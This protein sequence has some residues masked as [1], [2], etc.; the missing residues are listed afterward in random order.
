MTTPE[1]VARS[2]QIREISSNLQGHLDAADQGT[3]NPEACVKDGFKLVQL[4][5]ANNPAVRETGQDIGDA[6][7]SSIL[8]EVLPLF[9]RYVDEGNNRGI[10]ELASVLRFFGT[11]RHP[12][13][14]G[15]VEVYAAQFPEID[16]VLPTSLP[17]ET[18]TAE[19]AAASQADQMA[20]AIADREA[21][22]AQIE[23]LQ[24]R[25]E[26]AGDDL[27]RIEQG[28]NRV[29]DEGETMAN[30][31]IE[32]ARTQAA[33]HA[34]Q[35]A[36]TANGVNQAPGVGSATT[37]GETTDVSS[38]TESDS[39]PVLALPNQLYTPEELA[40]FT[41][42]QLE[43]LLNASQKK[44][45]VTGNDFFGEL[46]G[47]IGEEY[48]RRTEVGIDTTP[49]NLPPLA[50]TASSGPTV[51][52]SARTGEILTSPPTVVIS[53]ADQAAATTSET[54]TTAGPTLT[55]ELDQV[56]QFAA[57]HPDSE[58]IA[59]NPNLAAENRRLVSRL[60]LV[61]DLSQLDPSIID[62]ISTEAGFTLFSIVGDQGNNAPAAWREA[63]K[64]VQNEL[65]QVNNAFLNRYTEIRL[66]ALADRLQE[67]LPTDSAASTGVPALD[68]ERDRLIGIFGLTAGGVS[69]PVLIKTIKPYPANVREAIW[70][71]FES[72]LPTKE[73]A[74]LRIIDDLK[75]AVAI[76]DEIL[77][78]PK[79]NPERL[80]KLI[81][82]EDRADALQGQLSETLGLTGE[83]S[84]K[85]AYEQEKKANGVLR[86]DVAQQLRE[87]AQQGP[88]PYSETLAQ[89]RA[90]FE[91]VKTIPDSGS[92]PQVRA[93]LEKLLTETTQA[94]WLPEGPESPP[95][96]GAFYT[97][98][99]RA[100]G[101]PDDSSFSDLRLDY[102]EASSSFRNRVR[103]LDNLD[104]GLN[105]LVEEFKR[106][107]GLQRRYFEA[108]YQRRLIL[109]DYERSL[110]SKVNRV[111]KYPTKK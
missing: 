9:E 101:I 108:L 61:A 99:A 12:E 51:A 7:E 107:N 68:A 88:I 4:G 42:D 89:L 83:G 75:K 29:F 54:A 60:S 66:V 15:M 28:T 104:E 98:L 86:M 57:Q 10:I 5:L 97:E 39:A 6:V 81:E 82:I 46:E 31:A 32:Q 45:Y 64:I 105:G 91:G 33:N 52:V 17:E 48:D 37:R 25:L 96:V 49:V 20:Q 77:R 58:V 70:S 71:V 22:L 87:A 110:A 13:I 84:F 19:V 76:R 59:N 92:S 102:H 3:F 55:E 111:L 93:A 90:I 67:I 8:D 43:A 56:R 95:L 16:K 26:A 24:R 65:P 36:D 27:T 1:G 63:L 100:A 34:G 14:R 79:S 47:Q 106:K 18:G 40:A 73:R 109:G 74:G 35:L 103:D 11:D 2:E 80:D 21:Q 78:R 50:D 44:Y 62:Y 94:S 72:K 38:S 41:P 30:A 85:E 23:Q 53:E 69:M